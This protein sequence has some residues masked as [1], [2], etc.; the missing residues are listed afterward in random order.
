MDKAEFLI[1][2]GGIAGLAAAIAVAPRDTILLEQASEWTNAGAGLQLGPNAVRA[3]Q[4][5][6][7]WDAVEPI[8]SSPPEIHI[9]DGVSGK[10]LT[11]WQLGAS[12]EK[13]FGA[14]YRVAHRADVHRALLEVAT[15]HA[16]LMIHVR[17]T[18]SGFTQ[19]ETA[20]SA[21]TNRSMFQAE[22]LLAADGV[23]S[24]IRQKLFAKSEPR[25]TDRKSVV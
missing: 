12:F 7:A 20:V 15:T 19:T 11:R 25:S 18:V 22:K 1:A 21:T 4:K 6:G 2:G 8:T 3:L 17:Q 23:K 5:L 13:R 10:C 9:H 24:P 14:P 16:N